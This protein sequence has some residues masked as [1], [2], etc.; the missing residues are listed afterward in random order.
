MRRLLALAGA[1]ALLAAAPAGATI[2]LQE[3]MAK[4][5]LGMTQA[6]VRAARGAPDSNTTQSDDILG[7]TRTYKYGKVTVVFDGTSKASRV[8]SV[9]TKGKGER[10]SAGIGVGSKKADVAAKVP[11]VKCRHESGLNHCI[12]GALKAGRTVTDFVMNSHDRVTGV[13]VAIVVD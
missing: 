2:V 8:Y 9:Y 7:H 10:T 6:K 3:G 13:V 11:G 1:V 4:V 12:I 5:K